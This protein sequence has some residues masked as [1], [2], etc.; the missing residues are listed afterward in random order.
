MRL[1]TIET[2]H[3]PRFF[4]RCASVYSCNSLLSLLHNDTHAPLLQDIMHY[5][6]LLA[7]LATAA[8]LAAAY[9]DPTTNATKAIVQFPGSMM[10]NQWTAPRNKLNG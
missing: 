8:G 1:Y 9:N 4:V 2:Q 7:L 3:G 6:P 5:T 10:S